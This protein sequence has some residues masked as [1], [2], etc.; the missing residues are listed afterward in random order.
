MTTGTIVAIIVV[1]LVVAAVIAVVAYSARRRRLQQQFG[2][3]YDRAVEDSGSRRKAEAELSEREKRVRHL[4]IQPLDPA[5][6]DSYASQWMAIQ[7][8]FVDSPADA[9]TGA[10]TLITGVMSDRGYP[11]EDA[12][13]IMAD[14][15]VEH[16][17]TLEH[18]R[19]AQDLSSRAAG[20]NA[21]TEDLRQAMVHYRSLFQELLGDPVGLDPA[22]TDRAGT[23][24]AGTDPAATSAAVADPVVADPQPATTAELGTHA[25]DAGSVAYTTPDATFADGTARDD[26]MFSEPART[27]PAPTDAAGADTARADTARADTARTDTVPADVVPASADSVTN[28]STAPYATTDESAAEA[29]EED[30]PAGAG[31]LFRKR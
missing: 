16:A 1:V 10:Q 3:E 5:A 28:G 27:D 11:T 30:E 4:D 22:G 19:D 2:P 23:D 24:P 14:L 15:S 21:S 8:Q 13:Q 26:T 7:E 31:R 12:A 25:S 20:G 29:D 6:R 18:F 17:S 9:V